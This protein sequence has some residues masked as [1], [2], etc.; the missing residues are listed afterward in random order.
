MKLY[1]FLYSMSVYVA[2]YLKSEFIHLCNLCAIL[3]MK[4]M[5]PAARSLQYSLFNQCLYDSLPL[6]LCV[7]HY[8]EYSRNQYVMHSF[9][10]FWHWT[11]V[12][13]GILYWLYYRGQQPF[14]HGV[15]VY[16]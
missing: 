13:I 3:S 8:F 9:P 2:V 6:D 14:K 12:L 10:H 5:R 16:E 4:H 1:A 15:Q 11:N 7:V